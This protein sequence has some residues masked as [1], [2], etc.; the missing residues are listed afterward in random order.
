MLSRLEQLLAHVRPTMA[1]VR[2]SRLV[3]N[4]HPTTYPIPGETFNY[5]DSQTIELDT[6]PL[7]G[8]ILIKVIVLSSD[9]YLRGRMRSPEIPS[10]MPAMQIGQPCVTTA[11]FCR[12]VDK[13]VSAVWTTSG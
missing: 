7:N 4:A 9:P 13:Y 2:N 1:P 5:D 10:Y 3:Y 6:V 8:G 11:V 12:A